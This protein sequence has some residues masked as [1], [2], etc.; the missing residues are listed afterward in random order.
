MDTMT[1]LKALVPAQDKP[2][3]TKIPHTKPTHRSLWVWGLVLM[4]VN[5]PLVWGDIRAELVFFS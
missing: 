1:T 5:L 3:A 2:G 4:L